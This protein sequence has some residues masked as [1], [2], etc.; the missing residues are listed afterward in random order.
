MNES[1]QSI[2]LGGYFDKPLVWRSLLVVAIA[3][4]SNSN[5]RTQT[6]VRWL[7]ISLPLLIASICR[8]VLAVA[9]R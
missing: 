5:K 3:T 4:K 2:N 7:A 9:W 6:F 8:L 1:N